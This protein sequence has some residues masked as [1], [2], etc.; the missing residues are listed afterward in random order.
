VVIPILVTPKVFLF[1]DAFFSFV[2]FS[3]FSADLSSSAAFLSFPFL[4]VA[5]PAFVGDA[6]AFPFTDR[7]SSVADPVAV[8]NALLVKSVGTDPP[9]DLL[10]LILVS[11]I[12][13]LSATEVP[14]AGKI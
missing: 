1:F 9:T 3:G 13:V 7:S 10:L 11:P 12:L 2:T 8:S 14:G 4:V 6:F 5:A